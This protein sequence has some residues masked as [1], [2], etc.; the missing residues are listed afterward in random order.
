MSDLTAVIRDLVDGF[1]T[2]GLPY[3]IMGGI[4]VRAHGIPPETNAAAAV[5]EVIP[6]ETSS[7]N[8]IDHSQAHLS[9]ADQ[10]ARVGA[11]RPAATPAGWDG[12]RQSGDGRAASQPGLEKELVPH[13][14]GDPLPPLGD[15]RHRAGGEF[16]GH[17]LAKA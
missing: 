14:D 4:A 1:E 12:C 3:A 7:E 9:A 15:E 10:R 16:R 5:W 8:A 2:F 6:S 13:R 17:H 11:A